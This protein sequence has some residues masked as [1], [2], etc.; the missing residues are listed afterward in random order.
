M[1]LET[2][3]ILGVEI[4]SAGGPIHGVGSP[5][6]GDYW[7]PEQLRGMADAAAD[8]GDEVKA[9]A[10]IGHKGGDP[11]VGWL[12]NV[13]VNDDGSRLLADIKRVPKGLSSLID[14]GAYRTR[15]VELSSITSQKT[16][17]K[18]D[19]VVSGLAWLGGKMPAVR[20]LADVVKLYE[21]DE[22][23]G[24]KFVEITETEADVDDLRDGVADLGLELVKVYADAATAR[25]RPPS[26]S[27]PVPGKFTEEQRRTFAEATG[28]EPDKV[29][30]EMLA[31]SAVAL[32]T[33]KP[34][35]D[36][37]DP[38]RNLEADERLRQF[39]EKLE[40]S[41][42]RSRKLE[43]ELGEERRRNFVDGVLKDGKA[44]PGQ[45]ETIEALYDASP[46]VARKHFEGVKP[47][48]ALAREYGSDEDSDAVD[49]EAHERNYAADAARRFGVSAEEVV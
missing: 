42:A 16:G 11:A 35:A 21:A 2:V 3:D 33:E 15:S 44:E 43:E 47:N 37:D 40:A 30:D 1:P 25:N 6:A 17:R 14:A 9:P 4:L 45:R 41:D 7:S 22:D 29:T 36:D 26:D 27:S 38:A 10:K 19:W 12:E 46:E 8:L 34:K 24:R 13:R 31:A 20:T 32:E 18:H 23:P 48:D 49:D 5:P 39:E 28:L